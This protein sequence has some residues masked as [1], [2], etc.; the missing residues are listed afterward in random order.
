MIDSKRR[1]KLTGRRSE[2]NFIKLEK[3]LLNSPNFLK[4]SPRAVKL[5]V[6]LSSYYNGFNNGDI[7]PTMT[8][9]RSRGWASNANLTL[10]LRELIYYGFVK[11]TRQGCKGICTLIA[12]TMF[13][14]DESRK[15]NMKGKTP[16]RDYRSTK[17][18]FNPKWS[19]E[20]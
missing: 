4:L 5:L 8:F 15:H 9:M 2:G 6:D 11:V 10:A 19:W 14:I 1:L 12:L 16:R 7:T 17:K 13:P 20:S 18:K 3:S